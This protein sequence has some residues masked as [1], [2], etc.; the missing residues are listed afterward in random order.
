MAEVKET[1]DVADDGNRKKR[2][3]DDRDAAMDPADDSLALLRMPR[4]IA[5]NVGGKT[6]MTSRM[7]FAAAPPGSLLARMFGPDADPRWAPP[8]LPGGAY[9]LDLN[10]GAFAVVIDVLRHGARVLDGLEPSRRHMVSIVCDYLGISLARPRAPGDDAIAPE[11]RM[12]VAV[13]HADALAPNSFGLWGYANEEEEEEEEEGT[14]IVLLSRRWSMARVRDVVA[15]VLELDPERLVVHQCLRRVNGTVRPEARLPLDSTTVT[16]ADVYRR[17]RTRP[18]LFAHD[19]SW[20]PGDLPESRLRH[21]PPRTKSTQTLAHPDGASVL[22]FVKRLDR[23]ALTLSKATPVLVDPAA[24]MSAALPRMRRAL[25]IA[26]GTDGLRVFEEISPRFVE[27]VDL[28]RTL[29][30]NRLGY[31]DILWVETGTAG[32]APP[33]ID[34]ARLG[35]LS[36][37]LAALDDDAAAAAP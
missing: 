6:M 34:V 3:H 23:T 33:P 22:L 27:A 30:R 10:P 2:K 32:S 35:H 20:L 14:A 19:A 16:L 29:A 9:F 12:V 25:G 18:V 5:L 26:D 31:G 36:G 8:R 24:P 1:V 11:D 4:V 21:P 15:S 28:A 7:T 17:P 13:S 37:S